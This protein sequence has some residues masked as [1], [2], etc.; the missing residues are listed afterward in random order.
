MND[1]RKD[2]IRYRVDRAQEALE[3][4]RLMGEGVG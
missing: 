3:E 2:L 4:A 1:V